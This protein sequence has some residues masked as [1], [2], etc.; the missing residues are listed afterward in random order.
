MRNDCY[1]FSRL[2]CHGLLAGMDMLMCKFVENYLQI[3]KIVSFFVK[4]TLFTEIV[5]QYN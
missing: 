2:T 5:M 1:G 4:K 3:K